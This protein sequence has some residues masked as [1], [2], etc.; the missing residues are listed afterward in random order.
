MV[1]HV[2]STSAGCSIASVPPH[3][4]RTVHSVAPG[5]VTLRP[6]GAA[7]FAS[8]AHPSTASVARCDAPFASIT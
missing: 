1:T 2:G 8:N 6:H 4:T 3:V 7:G 5:A